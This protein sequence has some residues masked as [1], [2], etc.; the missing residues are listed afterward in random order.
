[1]IRNITNIII[2]LHG[3][4]VVH[5]PLMQLQKLGLEPSVGFLSLTCLVMKMGRLNWVGPEQLE[6]LRAIILFMVFPHFL[7][8][9]ICLRVARLLTWQVK[10]LTQVF[11]KRTRQSYTAFSNLA[12]EVTRHYFYYILFVKEVTM[13]HQF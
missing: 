12:L 5:F 8:L 10:T 7:G 1:M 3:Y 2:V 13:P 6:L 4:R 9:C 11:H